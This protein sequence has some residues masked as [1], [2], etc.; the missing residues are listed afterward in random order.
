MFKVNNR[1]TRTKVWNMFKVNNK[2]TKTM[3]LLSGIVLVSLML[4]LNMFHTFVL[5]FLLLTL[6]RWMPAGMWKQK[7]V[8][9][10]KDCGVIISLHDVINEILS[11]YSNWDWQ[12]GIALKF[13]FSVAKGLKVSIGKIVNLWKCQYCLM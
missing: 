5:V 10:N 1:N 2:D 9:W 8:S 12:L 3:P 4:T 6:G 7:K 11:R 13:Y